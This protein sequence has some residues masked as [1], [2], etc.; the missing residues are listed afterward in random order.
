MGQKMSVTSFTSAVVHHTESEL[1]ERSSR[2][3]FRMQSATSACVK[4]QPLMGAIPERFEV[5][6]RLRADLCSCLPL[7][8]ATGQ[9]SVGPGHF[10]TSRAVIGGWTYARSLPLTLI[11]QYPAVND[12][13]QPINAAQ[14]SIVEPVGLS[15]PSGATDGPNTGVWHQVTLTGPRT[16]A[17]YTVWAWTGSPVSDA[18]QLGYATTRAASPI[19]VAHWK[20]DSLDLASPAGWAEKVST[21]L[22]YNAGFYASGQDLYLRLPG[23]LN[24]NTLYITASNKSHTAVAINGPDIRVSGFEIRQFTSGVEVM[25]GARNATVD[26]D[27]LTGNFTG[28]FFRAQG[29]TYGTD[30]VVQDNIVQDTSLWSTNQAAPAIPWMFIKSTIRNADGT[31][32]PTSNIGANAESAGITGRGGARRTVIRR[33]LVTGLFDGVRNGYFATIHSGRGLRYSSII[34]AG[35]VQAHR[36]ASSQGARTNT[37]SGFTTD[38]AV[39]NAGAGDLRL[40]AGSPLI[41]AGIP[42]PNISDRAG[43]DFQGSAPDIGFEQR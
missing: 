10:P 24:P 20:K 25:W 34:Y 23:G 27:L 4:P 2:Q 41:D 19:R 37:A 43:V 36:A 15:S 13:R 32:Y 21:N 39:L 6:T 5:C 29:S 40:P 14:R 42:V 26:H 30:H 1:C 18:T 35:N 17:A 28:I 8:A 3:N 38:V 9:S 22:T 11:A 12:D 31:D 7:G 33:N 16:G